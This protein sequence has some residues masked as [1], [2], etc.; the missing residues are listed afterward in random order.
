MN[1]LV[2]VGNA[3][4][5]K[6]I[7]MSHFNKLYVES[8]DMLTGDL[9]YDH[10]VQTSVNDHNPKVSLFTPAYNTFEKFNRCYNSVINQSFSD[11]EWI[12][13]DD[14]PDSKNYEYITDLVRDDYRIKVFKSNKQD[15]FIGSTKRQA[16]SLCNGDYLVELDHDD[17]LHHLALE[18][19]VDAFKK[20]PD[21]G[22][23]Y[24]NSCETFETGG[25]VRYGKGFGMGFGLHYDIAYKGK[26]L[27]GADVPINASTIRHIVGV[28]NHFRCWK[29]EMY[30]NLCRHNNKLYIVDDYELLV[31]TFLKT[32]MIHIPEVLY[33]QYMNSGGN[34]TQ[35]PRRAEIQRLV[36]AIQKK[37]D[38]KIHQRILELGYKD[39]LWNDRENKSNTRIRPVTERKN[40]AYVYKV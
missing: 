15:G 7:N 36:D 27:V 4:P 34:N 16:A 29:R 12:I 40:F 32:K 22:F 33:I 38:N 30:F 21:A 24:S 9:I 10:Y 5:F 1:L 2:I 6:K 26:Q 23:C 20:F 19:I 14:S 17:E 31:R 11:W 13:L 25:N 3:T 18:Y 28:P 37:Y 8:V 39:W 35:E